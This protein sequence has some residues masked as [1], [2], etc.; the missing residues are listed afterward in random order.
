MARTQTW[1]GDKSHANV[2]STWSG[3]LTI[4]PLC[5]GAKAECHTLQR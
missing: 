3:A 5:K 2:E 1:R 4:L